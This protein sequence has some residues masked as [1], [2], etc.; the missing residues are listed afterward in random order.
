[1]TEQTTIKYFFLVV[2]NFD[3]INDLLR[4]ILSLIIFTCHEL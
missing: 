4:K 3:K 1:M 2:N